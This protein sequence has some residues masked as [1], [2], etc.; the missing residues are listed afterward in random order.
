MFCREHVVQLHREIDSIHRLGAE[1]IVLGNG[2]PHFVAG[3]RETTHYDGPIYC[4]PQRA[5]Y[6]A[7]EL[8]RSRLL[9]FTPMA[10]ARAVRT[11]ARGFRQGRVQGDDAQQG[12]VVV[13]RSDGEILYYH[14]S[15]G[16]GD[17]AP[18]AAILAALEG[19]GRK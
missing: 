8:K 2:A 3:F 11:L 5:A 10:A 14:Q 13:I 18:T 6:R 7:A 17:N 15:S 16:A 1:L 4:D 9:N 19:N 12:G